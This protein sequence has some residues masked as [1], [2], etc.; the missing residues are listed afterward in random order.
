[1]AINGRRKEEEEAD[2]AQW[3]P[4]RTR[5][6]LLPPSEDGHHPV[7][8]G[9]GQHPRTEPQGLGQGHQVIPSHPLKPPASSSLGPTQ[10]LPAS[11]PGRSRRPDSSS[12]RSRSSSQTPSSDRRRHRS[13]SPRWRTGKN[14]RDAGPDARTKFRSQSQRHAKSPPTGAPGPTRCQDRPHHPPQS[15]EQQQG[16][17]DLGKLRIPLSGP[18][19][20]TGDS[21][22]LR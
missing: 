15:Q 16:E 1:M 2:R 6:P 9:A 8:G 11:S 7:R 13:S 19:S 20:R 17:R 4:Q 12:G 18:L 21:A 14:G 3:R 22:S 5:P 10:Q